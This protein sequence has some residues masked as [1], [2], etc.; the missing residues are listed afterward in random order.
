MLVDL[1]ALCTSF[2]I[3][4]LFI[5][6]I[7]KYTLQKNLVDVPGRRKIHKKFTPSLGGIG[8]FIG[9][10]ASIL[11]WVN[12]SAWNDIKFVALALVIAFI[13][14]LRDDLVPLKPIHK[15]IAQIFAALVLVVLLDMRLRSFY[16]LIG[17][18]WPLWI[19]YLITIFTII[20]ITNSFNLIDG[21]D[22]L[23]GTIATCSLGA[24]GIWFFFMGNT[25]FAV[26]TFSMIG[27]I[28]AF[29][30]F[31]WQP[32]QIFMGDTGSLVIGLFLSI[33]TLRFINL[34]DSLS[35]DSPLHFEAS[36]ATAGC[37]VIVP[38]IDTFRIIVL[39]V[40]KRQSPFKPDKQHI[41]HALLR[42]GMSHAKAALFLGGTQLFFI[43]AAIAFMKVGGDRIL[44]PSLLILTTTLSL[45][46]DWLLIKKIS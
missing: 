44:L 23:A 41:H 3:T 13:T 35:D 32:A 43:L 22:G 36:I 29:L 40:L 16:G 18:E 4:F 31:N 14:G 46:L 45:T 7:I 21:L 33:C 39:R 42:L 5:P 19:S 25:V 24:F 17:G 38:L 2:A 11:I 10:F 1:A 27:A 26:L 8:V 15:L 30:H 9:F 12:L 6:I 34:N 37:F 20:V 28:L